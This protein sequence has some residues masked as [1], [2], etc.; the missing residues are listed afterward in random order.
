MP[1]PPRAEYERLNAEYQRL[2]AAVDAL[3]GQA[4]Q[5]RAELQTQFKRITEMQ[6]I[7]DEER[8]SG[9]PLRIAHPLA[10]KHQ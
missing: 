5:Q 10:H 2:K 7:L 1:M 6:A 9:R 3:F 8:R 4:R